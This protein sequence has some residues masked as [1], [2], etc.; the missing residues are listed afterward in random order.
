MS[1]VQVK[2]NELSEFYGI[3]L[4]CEHTVDQRLL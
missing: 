4:I 2:S 1:H 3:I